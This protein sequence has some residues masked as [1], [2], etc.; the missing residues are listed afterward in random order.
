MKT[1]HFTNPTPEGTRDLRLA[2]AWVA[3]AL[4]AGAAANVWFCLLQVSR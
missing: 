3:A 1:R 2:L 4:I